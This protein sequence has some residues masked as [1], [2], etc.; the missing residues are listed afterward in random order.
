[1]PM[2]QIC[3]AR[4]EDI[5]QEVSKLIDLSFGDESV[6]YCVVFESRLNDSLDRMTVIDMIAEMVGPKHKV[7]LTEPDKV[8]LVQVFKAHCG[9][10]VL[11]NWA[12]NRKYNIQEILKSSIQKSSQ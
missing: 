5:R 4:I 2:Q 9:L 12:P 10:S 7:K 3:M 6:S 11:D 1:M 8:I